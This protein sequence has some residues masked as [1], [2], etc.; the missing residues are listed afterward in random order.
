MLPS[1][2]EFFF[3]GRGVSNERLNR[4]S[5]RFCPF[6]LF[7]WTWRF[8][9]KVYW[10]VTGLLPSFFLGSRK[11][12]CF[13]WITAFL[14]VLPSF[15]GLQWTIESSF[16]AIW[17]LCSFFCTWR[18]LIKVHWDVTGFLPSFLGFRSDS[19]KV[20]FITGFHRFQ[21]SLTDEFSGYQR[22]LFLFF[23][24][25]RRFSL[26]VDA[27]YFGALLFLRGLSRFHES[28]AALLDFDEISK[29]N[30][31]NNK[32]EKKGKKKKWMS[33]ETRNGTRMRR[34]AEP[35]HRSN[36]GP[37]GVNRFDDLCLISFSFLFFFIRFYSIP[38]PSK[39][40]RIKIK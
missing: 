24:R 28:H 5:R 13:L 30:N 22:F 37:G 33:I 6:V 1:F 31:N 27:F 39:K 15:L 17:F 34:P 4:V 36:G 21:L 26:I 7:C 25:F 14:R 23:F 35:S 11:E 32:Q 40:K 12:S 19:S 2:T 29:K 16:V 18:F 20:K 38:P 3:K 9:T 10:D 8:L